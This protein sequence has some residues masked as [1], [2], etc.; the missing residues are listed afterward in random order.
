M[1]MNLCMNEYFVVIRSEYADPILAR[2]SFSLHVVT[3]DV[4]LNT[5]PREMS[6]RWSRTATKRTR[7]ECHGIAKDLF[8]KVQMLIH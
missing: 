4:C 6:F 3:N 8:I 7:P 1:N 2:G 5:S